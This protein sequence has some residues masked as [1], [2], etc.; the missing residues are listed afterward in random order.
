MEVVAVHNGLVHCTCIV[1]C[2]QGHTHDYSDAQKERHNTIQ[3]NTRSETTFPKELRWDLNP[4]L[5]YQL[6]Y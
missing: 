5:R 1:L 6:S 4:H 2:I 3:H